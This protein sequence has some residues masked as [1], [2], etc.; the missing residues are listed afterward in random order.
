MIVLKKTTIFPGEKDPKDLLSKTNIKMVVLV[1]DETT[2]KNADRAARHPLN[3]IVDSQVLW[4][5]QPDFNEI[6]KMIPGLPQDLIQ[7]IYFTLSTNN[8]VVNIVR[9]NDVYDEMTFR[10]HFVDAGLPQYNNTSS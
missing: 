9:K 8:T 10:Q 5:T 3:D 4:F 7:V 2:A 6:H 1:N